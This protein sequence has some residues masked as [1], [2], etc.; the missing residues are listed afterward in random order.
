LIDYNR[1]RFK[2]WSKLP[3][4]KYKK[5]IEKAMTYDVDVTLLFNKNI[6]RRRRDVQVFDLLKIFSSNPN[7]D[8]SIAKIVTLE[9]IQ[10]SSY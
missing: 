9:H 3:D 6:D 2:E 10:H 1:P 8:E 7:I 4:P 5:R